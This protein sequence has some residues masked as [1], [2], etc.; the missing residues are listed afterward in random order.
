MKNP[1][2]KIGEEE[3]MELCEEFFKQMIDFGYTPAYIGRELA[4]VARAMEQARE[5]VKE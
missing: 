2:C 4:Y 3:K 1:Q 5:E